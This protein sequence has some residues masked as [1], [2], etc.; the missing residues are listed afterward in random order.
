MSTLQQTLG[1]L[2]CPECGASLDVPAGAAAV[3]CPRCREVVGI[4]EPAG[5][6]AARSPLIL[7]D[8]PRVGGPNPSKRPA[9]STAIWAV[10]ALGG[11]ALAAYAIQVGRRPAP[12][13]P[14]PPPIILPAPKPIAR[15]RP[16]PRLLKA[17]AEAPRAATA[18]EPPIRT[19][20]EPEA[21]AAP[22]A[23]AVDPAAGFES[24]AAFDNPT[25]RARRG[26]NTFDDPQHGP[27]PRNQATFDNPPAQ[28][29]N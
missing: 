22:P 28:R 8:T 11:V 24:N 1:R 10:V 5:P 19:V 16:V 9:D 25:G 13:A 23:R 6:T 3:R 7:V 17:V 14:E 27:M 12:K 26:S 29:P 21:P 15:A 18:P 2:A 20:V 4:E